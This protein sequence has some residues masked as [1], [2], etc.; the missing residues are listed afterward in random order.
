MLTV[1]EVYPKVLLKLHMLAD[2]ALFEFAAGERGAANEFASANNVNDYLQTVRNKLLAGWHCPKHHQNAQMVLRLRIDEEGNL[3]LAGI[4]QFGKSSE[5]NQSIQ[6]AIQ[7]ASPLPAPPQGWHKGEVVAVFNADNCEAVLEH[8]PLGPSVSFG[9][10]AR[11]S[12]Y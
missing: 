9:F 8:I 5:I 2:L 6:E 7:W 3:S 12:Y 1:A 11:R 4:N 10:P